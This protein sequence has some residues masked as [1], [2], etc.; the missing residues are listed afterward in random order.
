MCSHLL[1]VFS[2]YITFT[3]DKALNFDFCRVGTVIPIL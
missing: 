1:V 2:L 3:Y